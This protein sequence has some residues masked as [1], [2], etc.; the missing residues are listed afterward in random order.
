MINLL[1]DATNQP[2]QF[3]T[4]FWLELNDESEKHIMMMM[5]VTIMMIII[6][7]LELK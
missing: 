3:R 7:K 4:R 1:G 6:I 5:M 2:P